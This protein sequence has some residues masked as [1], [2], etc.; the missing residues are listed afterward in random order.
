MMPDTAPLFLGLD[1]STQALKASLLTS[2]LH[3]LSELEVRFDADLAHFNTKGGVLHGPEGSGEV[4]SP[5]MQPIAAMDMLCDKI[6]AAGWDVGR[7]R[8]VSAAGQVGSAQGSQGSLLM[9]ATRVSV[10][11]RGR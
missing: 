10:L 3:V 11:V 2:T 1:S 9:A 5:V 8:G 6:K 4:F 7:I